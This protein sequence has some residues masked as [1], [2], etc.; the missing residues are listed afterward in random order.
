[1]V[2]IQIGV[3]GE[4]VNSRI[5]T[6]KNEL[7]NK[8]NEKASTEQVNEMATNLMN[9]TQEVIRVKTANLVSQGTLDT[10][11]ATIDNTVQG[12]DAN[13]RAEINRRVNAVQ[14]IIGS[15]DDSESV[16]GRLKNIGEI[17]VQANTTAQHAAQGQIDEQTVRNEVEKQLQGIDVVSHS[18][19][20][21]AV[22]TEITNR[23]LVTVT[24]ITKPDG[25]IMVD[26]VKNATPGIAQGVQGYASSAQGYA[27]QAA[28]SYSSANQKAQDAINAASNALAAQGAAE[29][30]KKAALTAQGI[31][32]GTVDTVLAAQGAAQGYAQNAAGSASTALAAQGAAQGYAQ[33]AAGSASTANTYKN[34]AQQAKTNAENAAATAEN[35]A[36]QS[37]EDYIAVGASIQDGIVQGI[38]KAQD[39]I[40]QE[41]GDMI[42]SAMENTADLIDFDGLAIPVEQSE[43]STNESFNELVSKLQEKPIRRTDVLNKVI[44]EEAYYWYVMPVIDQRIYRDTVIDVNGQRVTVEYGWQKAVKER[45]WYHKQDS[46]IRDHYIYLFRT[47]INSLVV[48]ASNKNSIIDGLPHFLPMAGEKRKLRTQSEIPSG[49]CVIGNGRNTPTGAGQRALSKT[50]SVRGGVPAGTTVSVPIA[51]ALSAKSGKSIPSKFLERLTVNSENSTRIDGN[52][53]M[54]SGITGNKRKTPFVTRTNWDSVI[55]GKNPFDGNYPSDFYYIGCYAECDDSSMYENGMYT[56]EAIAAA[57]EKG[58]DPSIFSLPTRCI[59]SQGIPETYMVKLRK[60]D[61]G[62]WYFV[63]KDTEEYI[64]DSKY[65]AYYYEYVYDNTTYAFAKLGSTLQDGDAYRL[66]RRPFADV[67]RDIQVHMLPIYLLGSTG[68]AVDSADVDGDG[69]YNYVTI[70]SMI[71]PPTGTKATLIKE[72]SGEISISSLGQQYDYVCKDN[73]ALIDSGLPCVYGQG[74]TWLPLDAKGEADDEGGLGI[75]NPYFQESM[76]NAAGIYAA[77]NGLIPSG[78]TKSTLKSM[79]TMYKYK[80]VEKFVLGQWNTSGG[81]KEWYEG[82]SIPI[83]TDDYSDDGLADLNEEIYDI[84]ITDGLITYTIKENYLT[85]QETGGNAGVTHSDFI[86]NTLSYLTEDGA[87]NTNNIFLICVEDDGDEYIFDEYI[88]EKGKVFKLNEQKRLKYS[89]EL[90]KVEYECVFGLPNKRYNNTLITGDTDTDQSDN[91]LD[92]ITTTELKPISTVPNPNYIP[93]KEEIFALKG[94]MC[95]TSGDIE[96]NVNLL[97]EDA[98]TDLCDSNALGSIIFDAKCSVLGWTQGVEISYGSDGKEDPKDGEDPKGDEVPAGEEA[99]AEPAEGGETPEEYVPAYVKGKGEINTGLLEK[100]VLIWT[101]LRSKLDANKLDALLNIEIGSDSKLSDLISHLQTSGIGG[102]YWTIFGDL[103]SADKESERPVMT[104]LLAYLRNEEGNDITNFI[105]TA[106]RNYQEFIIN[107]GDKEPE[108]EKASTVIDLYWYVLDIFIFVVYLA[109]FGNGANIEDDSTRNPFTEIIK[110]STD[111]NILNIIYAITSVLASDNAIKSGIYVGCFD[112]YR[113]TKYWN[114]E[115]SPA[116]Q[117]SGQ[118]TITMYSQVRVPRPSQSKTDKL[119]RYNKILSFLIRKTQLTPED[120]SQDIVYEWIYACYRYMPASKSYLNIGNRSFIKDTTPTYNDLNE[121][122]EDNVSNTSSSEQIHRLIQ[123][124]KQDVFDR[125]ALLDSEDALLNRM[126]RLKA[127]IEQCFA[128]ETVQGVTTYKVAGVPS[129]NSF[130]Q[131]VSRVNG[132]EANMANMA[133][134]INQGK[135]VNMIGGIISASED[136]IF[137][138]AT[139]NPQSQP[140]PDVA[141]SMEPT[142]VTTPNVTVTTQ[143]NNT[144]SFTTVVRNIGGQQQTILTRTGRL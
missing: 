116:Q 42:E 36:T 31:T 103:L 19:L 67:S 55:S 135:R 91:I 88:I 15:A 79:S 98:V 52:G 94:T 90:R 97:S 12:V 138:G 7:T 43:D 144:R 104:T 18:Q 54:A 142:P 109:F 51:P 50:D 84:N 82:D 41:V 46:N 77:Y 117:A 27:T 85:K 71:T 112:G 5:L 58:D 39:S 6:A 16:L 69:K 9:Q 32:Q 120:N 11:K 70:D 137:T 34:Q 24:E 122:N 81:I 35:W 80:I 100:L 21:G 74:Y 29:T 140:E 57:I 65:C 105:S 20:Q 121:I 26:I 53:T 119:Q 45:Y 110:S 130:N 17:A 106:Y 126:P 133:S 99:P 23:G 102:S 76:W 3:D 56:S 14:T 108:G 96:A 8:I 78:Y 87:S 48:K 4:V 30:A 59:D 136:A 129:S 2:Q 72:S 95:S 118:P 143:T 63:G 10:M 113:G 86:T 60:H 123:S 75:T 1:M 62:S 92:Y 44:D 38:A 28:T 22:Q 37:H 49:M 128:E 111:D 125:I 141:P 25:S 107:T 40:V 64:V 13:V 132:S 127:I 101:S 47:D 134:A 61:D 83:F 73:I 139:V 33:N 68:I 124:T 115:Y 89:E 66:Q 114:A 131:L 93:A